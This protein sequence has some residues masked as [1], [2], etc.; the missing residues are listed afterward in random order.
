MKKQFAKGTNKMNAFEVERRRDM[1]A[2]KRQYPLL[3]KTHLPEYSE[4]TD[5]NSSKFWNKV[6]IGGKKRL[7]IHACR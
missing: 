1:L 7:W 2:K 6:F 5:I 4:I 3:I